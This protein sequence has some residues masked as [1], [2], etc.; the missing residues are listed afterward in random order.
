M[1]IHLERRVASLDSIML[2]CIIYD[3]NKSI[4]IKP[5]FHQDV[6]VELGQITQL[7]LR[8]E[9]FKLFFE[10]VCI[11]IVKQDPKS[12]LLLLKIHVEYW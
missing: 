5:I 6:L 10:S 1:T 12:T 4:C 11:I 3:S 7:V 2:G 8:L 9:Y